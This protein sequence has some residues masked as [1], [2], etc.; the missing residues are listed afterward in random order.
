[1]VLC[2]YSCISVL[3]SAEEKL[4]A[5]FETAFQFI[6]EGVS[7]GKTHILP[8]CWFC[9]SFCASLLPLPSL[10][11]CRRWHSRALLR[12]EISQ[13]DRRIAAAATKSNI[14]VLCRYH[15]RYRLDHGHSGNAFLLLLPP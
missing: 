10:L 15:H 13:C 4:S 5:H 1:M 2:R 6:E 11:C 9:V 14:A 12:G 7:K 8:C 3:D